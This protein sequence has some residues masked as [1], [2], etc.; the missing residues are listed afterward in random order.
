MD[1]KNILLVLG[2]IIILFI[3]M[4]NTRYI[5]TTSTPSTTKS[6]TVIYKRP[7]PVVVNPHYNSYKAQYYN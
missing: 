7:Y 3:I 1:S 5:V 2:L 4:H 6:T